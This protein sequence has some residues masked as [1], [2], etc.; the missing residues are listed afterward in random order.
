MLKMSPDTEAKVAVCR[1]ESSGE[2][3]V[4]SPLPRALGPNNNLHHGGLSDGTAP[5]PSSPNARWFSTGLQNTNWACPTSAHRSA[6]SPRQSLSPV[7]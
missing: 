7:I 6:A 4:L 1:T 2:R 5:F 3:P